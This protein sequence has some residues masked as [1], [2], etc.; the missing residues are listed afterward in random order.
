MIAL[1]G[2][3]LSNEISWSNASNLTRE[4]IEAD[5]DFYGFLIMQNMIKKETM[6]VIN[7]LHN[8]GL[9]TVMVTGDNLLTALNV[10]RKCNLVN[11]KNKV[12]CVDAHPPDDDQQAKIEW[13]LAEPFNEPTSV[14]TVLK[15]ES[16]LNI[17]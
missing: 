5:L 1:A 7:E 13:K 17:K 10:A 12:I 6:P 16:S 8:A 11:K 4:K 14:N 9:R 15:F 3:S 2:K